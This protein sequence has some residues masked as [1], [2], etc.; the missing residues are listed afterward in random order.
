MK[1][2]A[3]KP[4]LYKAKDYTRVYE[5]GEVFEMNDVSYYVRSQRGE[6]ELVTDLTEGDVVNVNE[7]LPALDEKPARKKK[8]ES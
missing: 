4:I 7:G 3:L 5:K 2:V 8:N 1:V 6:V